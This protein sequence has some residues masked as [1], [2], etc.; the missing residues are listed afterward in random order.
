ME[1][2]LTYVDHLTYKMM[3]LQNKLD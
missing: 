3:L 1:K 2:I